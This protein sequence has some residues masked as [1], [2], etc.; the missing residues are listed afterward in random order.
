LYS[1]M[2]CLDCEPSFLLLPRF[3]ERIPFY[4]GVPVGNSLEDRNNVPVS[5]ETNP[6]TWWI[7][8]GDEKAEKL[9]EFF[10]FN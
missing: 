5:P 8:F 6:D 1:T 3:I 7:T 4:F 10:G 9:R 2:L